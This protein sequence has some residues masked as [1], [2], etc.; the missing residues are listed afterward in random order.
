MSY[1]SQMEQ[2]E[3]GLRATAYIWFWAKLIGEGILTEQTDLDEVKQVLD[4]EIKKHG[5]CTLANEQFL[6]L[7]LM[8]K[9]ALQSRV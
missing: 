7:T 3:Y 6:H 1:K 8:K 4:I 9:T 2:I 5:L